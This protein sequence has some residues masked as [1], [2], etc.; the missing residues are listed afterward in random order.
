M[1]SALT[2]QLQAPKSSTVCGGEG[3]CLDWHESFAGIALP[4][5]L[6]DNTL[7]ELRGRAPLLGKLSRGAMMSV[8]GCRW[9]FYVPNPPNGLRRACAMHLLPR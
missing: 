8:M 2:P 7:V 9:S 3:E 1:T 4:A 6:P 5:M